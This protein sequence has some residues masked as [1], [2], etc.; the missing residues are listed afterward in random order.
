M[1]AAKLRE[2]E[3]MG[4]ELQIMARKLPPGLTRDNMLYE[5]G[6]LRAWVVALQADLPRESQ[7]QQAKV[8]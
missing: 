5:I 4:T 3:E 7:E 6:R 1:R 8:N 2:L